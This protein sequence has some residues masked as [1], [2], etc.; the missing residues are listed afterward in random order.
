MAVD[1]TILYRGCLASCN[2]ACWYCPRPKKASTAEEIETDRIGLEKFVSW[3]KN[4]QDRR[5]SVFFTPWGEATVHHWYQRAVSGLSRETHLRRVAIQTNLS[6]DM[7]WISECDPTKV[8]LWCTYHPGQARRDKFLRSCRKLFETGVGFSVGMVGIKEHF[9][10]IQTMRRELPTQIYLWINAYKDQENYYEPEE[11]S[12]LTL[13]DPLFPL[14]AT[15]HVSLGRDCRCGSEVVSVD[16]LGTI[17]RC[18]FIRTS[19]GSVYQGGL[20]RGLEARPCSNITCWCH[21]GYVHMDGL[22]G[23]EIYGDG[24]LERIPRWLTR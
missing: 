18:P 13:I 9:D 19:L 20:E 12:S 15:R 23:D 17:R 7:S 10:E 4:R 14:N 22:S 3:I 2:Y 24:I 5:F 21:I 8:G 16:H 11:I 6:G 1:L